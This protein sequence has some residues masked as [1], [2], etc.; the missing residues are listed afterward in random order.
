MIG[1]RATW[2]L[3]KDAAAAW[4]ADYVSS[5]GAALAY[6]TMFSVAPLLIIVIA[7]AGLVFGP[8]AA[9]GALFAQLRG[10]V[11]DEGAMA[12]QG[13]VKSASKPGASIAAAI[14]GVVTLILGA[15]T[16][17]GELQTSL[18][19]IWRAPPAEDKGLWKLLRGRVL[20]FGLILVLGFLLLVS[21]VLSAVIAAVGEWWGSWLGAKWML[22]ALNFF[23]S[24][25]VITSLFAMIYKILPRV[26]IGWKDVWVGAVVTA[27]LFTVGKFL[28]GLYLGKSGVQSGFGAASSVVVLL[29]WVYY[30][31]QIFLFGAEFTFLYAYR[32]GSRRDQPQPSGPA[33]QALPANP[34]KGA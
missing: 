8:D 29:V 21:L 22:E 28:I 26:R 34:R 14:G 18:D 19:R 31:A 16:V 30:S 6:Y 32:Y 2:S 33:P 25:G 24:L 4:K 23:V 3:C 7:V 17:L 12:V 15:T 1:A 27:F 13:L 9:S 5:M 10:L 20:S 11:G